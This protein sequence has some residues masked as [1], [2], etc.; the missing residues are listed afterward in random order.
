MTMDSVGQRTTLLSDQQVI[1]SLNTLSRTDQRSNSGKIIEK[2][3][4]TLDLS[5]TNAKPYG[6]I[7]VDNNLSSWTCLR[8]IQ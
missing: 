4:Y 5:D 1:G 3:H 8:Q 6:Y 2:N 7:D